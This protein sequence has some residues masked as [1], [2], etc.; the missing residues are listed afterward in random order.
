MNVER[1]AVMTNDM[2]FIIME[3]YD[4][5]PALDMNSAKWAIAA[6]TGLPETQVVVAPWNGV[7][8]EPAPPAL[9]SATSL[10]EGA[11][12]VGDAKPIP[13]SM[14]TPA[15]PNPAS[16]SSVPTVPADVLAS[17]LAKNAKAMDAEA[18]T[19]EATM[20]PVALARR[21]AERSSAVFQYSSDAVMSGPLEATVKVASATAIKAVRARMTNST[22]ITGALK[23]R[24][25]ELGVKV[26]EGEKLRAVVTT[27]VA[28]TSVNRGKAP[29][30]DDRIKALAGVGVVTDVKPILYASD[31]AES[32]EPIDTTFNALVEFKANLDPNA[33][34]S[35][36]FNQSSYRELM[37]EAWGITKEQLV[38]DSSFQ[39]ALEYSFSPAVTDSQVVSALNLV[40]AL[41]NGAMTAKQTGIPAATRAQFVVS[42]DV[43]DEAAITVVKANLMK[44]PTLEEA[45]SMLGMQVVIEYLQEYPIKAKFS[46][47]ITGVGAQ[48]PTEEKLEALNNAL[49]ATVTISDVES[50]DCDD[51]PAGWISAGGS[52]CLTYA[53]ENFCTSSRGYGPNWLPVHGSFWS[54]A[55]SNGVSA[56]DA[57][58]ECGGG[59]KR[60]DTAVVSS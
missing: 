44:I 2:F 18:A 9:V 36:A 47:G 8:E 17:V 7:T 23:S 50:A 30:D 10:L 29:D 11:S 57:C 26:A 43:P 1:S 35:S 14:L 53:A 54:W 21:N 40:A 31:K 34:A 25:I 45:F 19:I 55:D 22:L 52:T 13:K 58:C 46:N 32:D 6:V 51:S 56:V 37:A 27:T 4:F 48:R 60:S 59:A 42:A 16:L 12:V 3:R 38:V 20:D 49:G 41:P 28:G 15:T 5:S 39:M 24:G 33:N